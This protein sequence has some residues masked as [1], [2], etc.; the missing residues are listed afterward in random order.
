MHVEDLSPK[1][2]S[3]A[4]AAAVQHSML[5]VQSLKGAPAS[6][7][8]AL[9]LTGRFMTN[10]ELQVWTLWE[11]AGEDGPAPATDAGL[12]AGTLRGPWARR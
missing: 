4:P 8:L 7:L 5:F 10:Q 11:G 3:A 1:P 12:G 6:V 9:A 2:G